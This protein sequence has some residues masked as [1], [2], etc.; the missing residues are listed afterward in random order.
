LTWQTLP[1]E[2]RD[3]AKQALTPRQYQ[4]WELWEQNLGYTRIATILNISTPA[5]RDRINRALTNIEHALEKR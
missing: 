4:A 5:A 1:P 3:T 2:I